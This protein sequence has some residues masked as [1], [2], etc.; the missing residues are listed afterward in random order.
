MSIGERLKRLRIEKGLTQEKVGNILGITKGAVQK[1]ESGQI[2]NFRADTIKQLCDLCG[3]APAYFVY[4][5]VEEEYSSSN[6]KELRNMLI[7]HFGQ[8]FINFLDVLNMLNEEG[9]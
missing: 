1:Y 5:H 6:S 2:T 3:I 9:N 8:R 7:A 4:D